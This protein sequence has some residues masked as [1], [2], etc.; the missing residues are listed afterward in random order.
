MQTTSDT[1]LGDRRPFAPAQQTCARRPSLADGATGALNLRAPS[2][3]SAGGPIGLVLLPA[4]ESG[5]ARSCSLLLVLPSRD[6]VTRRAAAGRGRGAFATS[7][8]TRIAA[9]NQARSAGRFASSPTYRPAASLPARCPADLRAAF[10]VS[11]TS[12][13]SASRTADSASSASPQNG[14]ESASSF[15]LLLAADAVPTPPNQC[16]A[17]ATTN[18]RATHA[19]LNPFVA[20]SALSIN[21]RWARLTGVGATSQL[22]TQLRPAGHAS[23]AQ[24]FAARSMPSRPQR[25]QE[26]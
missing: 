19:F 15:A 3:N 6:L 11:A 16:A 2:L 4:S 25:L 22:N 8:L 20:L 24:Q 12:R 9:D 10:F 14:K 7:A 21:Q 18:A 13:E 5:T 17:W 26:R 1:G 23:V